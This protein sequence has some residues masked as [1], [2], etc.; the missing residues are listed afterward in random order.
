[1][2]AS[3]PPVIVS[4][5]KARLRDYNSSQVPIEQQVWSWSRA[6]VMV[7]DDASGVAPVRRGPVGSIIRRHL[8]GGA[9]SGT[10]HEQ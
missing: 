9:R 1:M 7:E 4:R 6:E 10:R 3:G 2:V 8:V 5:W